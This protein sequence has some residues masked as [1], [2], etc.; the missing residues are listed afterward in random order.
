[1]EPS[2][3]VRWEQVQILEAILETHPDQVKIHRRLLL[4]PFYEL[5]D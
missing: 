4:G 2:E 3:E 5:I 1:M